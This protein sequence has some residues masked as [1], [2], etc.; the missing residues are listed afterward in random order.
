M[1][2]KLSYYIRC[3]QKTKAHVK[4]YDGQTKW[5]YFPIIT[6][7]KYISDKVSADIK[8]ELDSKPVYNNFFLKK[9]MQKKCNFEKR[10]WYIFSKLFITL[11]HNNIFGCAGLFYEL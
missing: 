11:Q 9:K 1:I 10:V 2:M 4:S 8:K 6:Y 7:W 5:M 3:F